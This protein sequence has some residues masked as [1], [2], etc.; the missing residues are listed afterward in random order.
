LS[1]PWINNITEKKTKKFIW[2][3]SAM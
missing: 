2:S 3:L 1:V